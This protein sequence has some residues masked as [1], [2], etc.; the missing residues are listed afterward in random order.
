[1]E[2]VK[3]M[4]ESDSPTSDGKKPCPFCGKSIAAAAETCP[5]CNRVLSGGATAPIPPGKRGINFRAVF[6]EVVVNATFQQDKLM[7]KMQA[8][9]H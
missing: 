4:S 6:A 1:M 7:S 9:L 5:F 2:G 8:G 3:T